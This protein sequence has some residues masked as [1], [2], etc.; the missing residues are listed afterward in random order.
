MSLKKLKYNLLISSV[1]FIYF[2]FFFPVPTLAK[3]YN[4]DQNTEKAETESVS[5]FGTVAFDLG[6]LVNGEKVR[7][8]DSDTKQKITERLEL[9]RQ[10][11]SDNLTCYGDEAQVDIAS[12]FIL[13][14]EK[15]IS[16]KTTNNF[17]EEI[18]TSNKLKYQT[19]VK[20]FGFINYNTT[21]E[22]VFKTHS[23]SNL[24]KKETIYNSPWYIRL[25]IW[26]SPQEE[27]Y[28]NI[29]E[30]FVRGYTSF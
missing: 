24:D 5:L 27:K 22:A 23:N 17:T 1:F 11:E 10:I 4:Q 21:A 3:T 14:D 12:F 20:L 19:T 13:E 28:S 8:L 9:C 18:F 26:N 16:F 30:H 6:F 7:G 15:I 25:F 2:L 29:L